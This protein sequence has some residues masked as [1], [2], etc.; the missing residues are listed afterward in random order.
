MYL[1]T[2]MIR[3]LCKKKLPEAITV[4]KN[5]RGGPM[6]YDHDHRFNGYFF[7]WLPEAGVSGN[8]SPENTGANFGSTGL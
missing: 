1:T 2:Q 7:L 3:K 4:L 8:Q 6:R 5:K